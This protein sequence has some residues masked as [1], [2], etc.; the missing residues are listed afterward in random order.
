MEY[1]DVLERVLDPEV[2]SLSL[3]TVV[4]LLDRTLPLQL[5]WLAKRAPELPQVIGCKAFFDG[6]LGSRTAKLFEPFVDRGA[7]GR[8]VECAAD[9]TDQAWCDAVVRAGLAPSVHA[10][11][12]AAVRRAA[13]VLADVPE[14]LRPTIEH[15]ELV[16]GAD[17]DAITRVRLSVQ[18]VHR[19]EDA[20]FAADIL[21]A[22]RA[23]CMLPLRDLLDAGARLA[24][25]TDW[26]ITSA[27][28]M[29]TLSA[30]ITG[31]DEDGRPFHPEQAIGAQDAMHAMTMGAAEAVFLPT[32]AGL[33]PGSPADFVVWDRDPLAWDGSGAPPRP[34][35]VFI[36]GCCVHGELGH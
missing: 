10:I 14:S 13:D 29:R 1:R 9:R 12:D 25:G 23:A 6:T 19:S 21:G 17:L 26:P 8:W 36:D 31:N 11:G 7:C 20:R 4:T 34:A 3:R 16:R 27:D 33:V 28:P 22:R 15:A 2:A 5:D 30:A 35:A 24:F 18:P 32:A